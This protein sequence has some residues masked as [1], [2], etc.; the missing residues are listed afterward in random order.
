MSADPTSVIQR[1]VA[2]ATEADGLSPLDEETLL[3]LKHDGVMRDYFN[4]NDD[5]FAWVHAGQLH[6]V[7]AP[8]ARI[9]GIGTTLLQAS[10]TGTGS[11]GQLTAWSHGDHPG[12]RSLAEQNGWA[13]TREL[14]MLRRPA[15]PTPDHGASSA[16][17]DAGDVVL[18]T[19]RDDDQAQ[20]L[21][22]NAA[23]FA[24]HP[25]QGALTSVGFAERVAEPWFDPTGLFIAE[26]DGRILGFHWTK[27]HLDGPDAG[28]G[29]VYV[30]AVHPD[31]QGL[32]L[33]R[34]LL[35]RGLA[36]LQPRDVILY[37]ESD[38][39]PAV[40]LYSS[41]GFEQLRR[42]V[43]YTSPAAGPASSAS[44]KSPEVHAAV[45]PCPGEHRS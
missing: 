30:M 8:A 9:H 20:L 39:E 11:R 24:H 15:P 36:H 44:P 4:G 40:A 41:L 27:V 22:V 25:E 38:N 16:P 35:E 28:S 43:Q 31:A 14:L 17:R 18:R 19:F 6:L 29:E 5:G 23:A 1:V 32:G 34:R 13:I 10:P 3:T 2:A 7:V 26:R 12:A 42:D 37:V 45:T 21:E 33:G